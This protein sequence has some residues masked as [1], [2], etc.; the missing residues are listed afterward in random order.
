MISKGFSLFAIKFFLAIL[1]LGSLIY[2]ACECFAMV[3]CQLL[4]FSVACVHFY[5]ADVDIYTECLRRA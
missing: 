4:V 5:D 3:V 2:F 1:L